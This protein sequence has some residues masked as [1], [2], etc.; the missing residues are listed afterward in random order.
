MR[1]QDLFV[2][3]FAIFWGGIM[4]VS[5][6]WRMFQPVLRYPRILSR[7]CLSLLMMVFLPIWYFAWQL[8]CIGGMEPSSTSAVLASVLP[9]LGIFVF[10]RL[11]MVIIE[12]MPRRF[13]WSDEEC[14]PHYQL[15]LID[16][17]VEKLNIGNG[18]TTKWNFVAA[19][20]YGFLAVGVPGLISKYV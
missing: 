2:L 7:F 19:L 9:S 17:S 8:Q 11:W 1:N 10:Y 3:F 18:F 14:I 13:Y 15:R 5:G 6:R 12:L 20:L 4:N 16:P